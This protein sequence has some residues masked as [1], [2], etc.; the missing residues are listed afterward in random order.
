M[1]YREFFIIGSPNGSYINYCDHSIKQSNEI[2]SKYKLKLPC[3]YSYITSAINCILHHPYFKYLK[4]NYYHTEYEKFIEN[5][6]YPAYDYYHIL[7]NELW[8]KFKNHKQLIDIIEFYN[9]ATHRKFFN[10]KVKKYFPSRLLCDFLYYLNNTL[11]LEFFIY[12]SFVQ[13]INPKDMT[14]NNYIKKILH[15]ANPNSIFIK[16]MIGNPFKIY[17]SYVRSLKNTESKIIENE[18]IQYVMDYVIKNNKINSYDYLIN[19][20]YL[21]S[22]VFIDKDFKCVYV[23]LKYDDNLN[24]IK[25]VRYFN[26]D[27]VSYD[28]ID[29]SLNLELNLFSNDGIN[30]YYSNINFYKIDLVCYVKCTK[31][32]NNQLN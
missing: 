25:K 22:F 28:N 4:D 19:D 23:K 16:S 17:N 18:C 7:N 3:D 5:G 12:G 31:I 9:N 32:N 29:Q 11:L 13:F 27:K 26:D 8:N 1:D 15:D 21:Q 14:T 10:N 20:Y 30:D 2:Y 24:V 6:I